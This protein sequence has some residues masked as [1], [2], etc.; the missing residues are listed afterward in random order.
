MKIQ[1]YLWCVI[2]FVLSTA[3]PCRAGDQLVFSVP[4]NQKGVATLM[5]GRILKQAYAE[6]N[7]D[8]EFRELP[9]KRALN[10]ANNGETDGEFLRIAGLEGEY[11]N[12]VMVPVSIGYVDVVVYTKK[13]EFEV[14]GWQSLRPYS[15]GFVRGF[16]QAEAR[17]KG[18][19]VHEVTTVEQ[20]FRKLDRG[21]TDV[22]VD[23]RS[24]QYRLKS[25]NV[26]GIRIL[27]PPLDQLVM[28][29]YLNRRH[30]L[31]AAKLEAVLKRMERD[32]ESKKI[33]EQAVVDYQ[34]MHE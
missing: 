8:F 24:T 3:L 1:Y 9:N 32:G 26:S 6:L 14:K 25:L 19:D 29:H 15:I 13:T 21:R 7:I 20:A 4:V 10:S 33:M 2:I 17:T 12:L 34:K 11:P 30:K 16:K 22:V 23:S 5:A 18:M 31:L 27:E 28:Y